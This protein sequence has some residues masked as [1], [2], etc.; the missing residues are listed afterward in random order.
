MKKKFT[1]KRVVASTIILVGI[2]VSFLIIGGPVKQTEGVTISSTSSTNPQ[3][4]FTVN[5]LPNL[6][7][8]FTDQALSKLV[9]QN[10]GNIDKKATTVP[11]ASDVEK[12]VSDI[13]DSEVA[14]ETPDISKV[15]QSTDD[16][17]EMQIAYLFA[18]NSIIQD[19]VLRT[20]NDSANT[21][22]DTFFIS[23]GDQFQQ[24]ADILEAMNIPPSWADIHAKFIAFY[25]AQ[26]NI[27]KSLG[28]G[29]DDPLR[30]MIALRR[31]PAQT[32]NAFNVLTD[33]I[34]KRIK[35]QKLS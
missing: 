1:K 18:L 4:G 31:V 5:P 17:K 20:P 10:Q 8:E 14:K 11:N 6:T 29:S 24:S 9:A 3:L 30:F 35:D 21:S 19:S 16:S 25:T 26:A 2:F 28:A 15:R 32:E 12:I 23:A 34:N 33:E 27:Y 13:I 22:L 7:N